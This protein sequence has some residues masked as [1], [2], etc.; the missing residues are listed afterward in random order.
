[1]DDYLLPAGKPNDPLIVALVGL[2][3][4]YRVRAGQSVWVGDYLARYP[5]LSVEAAV[6][7]ILKDFELRRFHGTALRREQYL[8]WFPDHEQV[9]NQR[10][11]G[12]AP[13]DQDLTP[14]AP[15]GFGGFGD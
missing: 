15:G 11:Q 14:H 5:E 13:L 10:L 12:L 6:E 2:D 4:E 9:L 8:A 1:M 7:L 3:L